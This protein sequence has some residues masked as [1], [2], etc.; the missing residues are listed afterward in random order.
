MNISRSVTSPADIKEAA[1]R[2]VQFVINEEEHRENVYEAKIYLPSHCRIWQATFTGPEGQQVWKS[3]G[4]TNRQLAL[5][6]ARRWEAEAHAQRLKQG[7]VAQK[8][9][10]RVHRSEVDTQAGLFTQRE[11]ALALNITER[12]VRRIERRAI[13]KLRRHPALRRLWRQFLSGGVDEAQ[14][15]LSVEETEA[16]L[17]LAHTTEEW[18][19]LTKILSL[20]Q[21]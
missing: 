13:E 7:I 9:L 2:I 8:P 4:M 10:I 6:V 14:L 3:T 5:L 21:H 12:A 19:L 11:T 20:V 16:L 17:G 18:E 15:I 1:Q